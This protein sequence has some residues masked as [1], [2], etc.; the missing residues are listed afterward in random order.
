MS[1]VQSKIDVLK[2]V[3]EDLDAAEK[4]M[5]SAVRAFLTYTDQDFRRGKFVKSEI[6]FP[7]ARI[8]QCKSI[9]YAEIEHLRN[10]LIVE[11][12]MQGRCKGSGE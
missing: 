4:A 10:T 1:A 9:V 11:Q 6:A 3:Y 5:E 2:N 12:E 7:W 8:T